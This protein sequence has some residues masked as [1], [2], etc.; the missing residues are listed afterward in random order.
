MVYTETKKEYVIESL[1][2]GQV[3]LVVDF[4]TMK[5]MDCANMTINT[6]NSYIAKPDTKFFKVTS[7]E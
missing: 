4:Q 6:I 2:K 5:V 1:G 3:V 7:N